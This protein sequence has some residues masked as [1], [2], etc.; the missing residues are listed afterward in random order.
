MNELQIILFPITALYRQLL[1]I[2]NNVSS[3]IFGNV[4]FD[5]DSIQWHLGTNCD[6]LQIVQ[7]I[8]LAPSFVT[9]GK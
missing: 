9:Q 6:P 4:F 8:R 3:K 1:K 5:W 7:G 2:K